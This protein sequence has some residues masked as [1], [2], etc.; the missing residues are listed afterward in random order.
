M[1]DKINDIQL[2]MRLPD[3]SLQEAIQSEHGNYVKRLSKSIYTGW[4]RKELQEYVSGA[5]EH[6]KCDPDFTFN[7]E[8]LYGK[9][10]WKSF[11]V[12]KRRVLGAIMARLV[13]WGEVPFK[14]SSD[15]RSWEPRK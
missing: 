14:F 5:Y 4:W 3:L 13:R 15:W 11:S 12:Y 7:L 8:T 10:V 9:S 2:E 1:N 6:I